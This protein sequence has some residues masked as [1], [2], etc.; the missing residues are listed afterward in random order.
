VEEASAPLTSP[1]HEE[2][3]SPVEHDFVHDD[4]PVPHEPA[5]SLE[6]SIPVQE[7]EPLL[8]SPKSEF[9]EE[10][11]SAST[12]AIASPVSP[13]FGESSSGKRGKKG[14]KDK[15][16]RKAKKDKKTPLVFDPENGEGAKE[17]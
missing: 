9:D 15:K 8:A 6:P 4:Y 12:S 14:K 17:E 7:I 10:T 5:P 13:S 16:E 2:I 3:P 11:A 1:I